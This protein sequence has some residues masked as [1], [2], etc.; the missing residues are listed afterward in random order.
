[1]HA[2]QLSKSARLKRVLKA[3]TEADKKGEALSTMQIIEQAKVCAVNSIVAELRA[4]GYPISCK[5]DNGCWFYKL[6]VQHG[7]G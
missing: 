2:A 1:M 3:L 5:R 7:H 4:N 6:E